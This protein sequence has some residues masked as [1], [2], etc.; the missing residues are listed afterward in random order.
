MRRRDG[1]PGNPILGWKESEQ[2]EIGAAY[3]ITK[4]IALDV[5]MGRSDFD[6]GADL[7]DADAMSFTSVRIAQGELES[8]RLSAWFQIDGEHIFARDSKRRGR[9]T[10]GLTV[11]RLSAE[12][13][14]VDRAGIENLGVESVS[15]GSE[16]IFG[17]GARGELRL[18][19]SGWALGGES[20]L[21]W[22][23]GGPIVEVRT[24]ASS[25][26]TSAEVSFDPYTILAFVGYHF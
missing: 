10:T 6:L 19:R 1:A 24:D 22:S 3:E 18:G 15:A 9:W 11:G 12:D 7:L 20:C 21:M 25:P 17:F 5:S 14:E 2:L 8:L 16:T 26:Y 13:V 4:S 23:S